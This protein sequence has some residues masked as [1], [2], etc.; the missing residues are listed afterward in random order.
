MIRNQQ[1]LFIFCTIFIIPI[2]ACNLPAR[3][4][5]DTRGTMQ[6]ALTDVYATDNANST[7][8]PINQVTIQPSQTL[9]L[10]ETVTAT[11]DTSQSSPLPTAASVEQDV[12]AKDLERRGHALIASSSIVGPKD[13]VYSAYLFQNT[14]IDPTVEETSPEFCRLAIYRLDADQNSLLRS[15]TAPQYPQSAGYSFPVSCDAVNW[16]HPSAELSWGGSITPDMRELLGFS[17]NWSDINQ[18]GLPEFA[19]HYQY[20]NQGCIDHGVVAVHFY[21][22]TNTYQPVDIT[23]ALPGVIQPWNIVHNIDPVDIWVYE[24]VEYEPKIYIE[25]SWIFSWNDRQ[26]IDVTSQHAA[27]FKSKIDQNLAIIQAEYGTAITH[28]R[29]DFLEILVF[30][31]KAKLPTE[32]S[33]ETFL[34]ITNPT[35][36][37]E[38][39]NS[40]RCWLQLARTYAQRDASARRPFSLPPSMTTINGPGLS[41]ILE[42]IDQDRYDVSACK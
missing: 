3:I 35:H 17:G 27:E 39:D 31:N 12:F 22:I 4:Q 15:F 2:L 34:D 42:T 33:L 5:P 9:E 10:S 41:D 13:F 19:V 26:F 1:N 38:T 14:K 18:N 23:A 37:P 30:S 21:E 36:W 8:E 40:L 29:T 6:A 20:C 16:D 11:P 28:T 32:Q 7:I 24:L 25:S